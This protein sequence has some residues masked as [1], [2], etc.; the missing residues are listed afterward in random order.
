MLI[1]GHAHF[2]SS[3]QH[4]WLPPEDC[5]W[6]L[7]HWAS[8]WANRAPQRPLLLVAFLILLFYLLSVGLHPS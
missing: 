5:D 3:A 6:P 4:Q 8:G 1:R 2:P 7:P